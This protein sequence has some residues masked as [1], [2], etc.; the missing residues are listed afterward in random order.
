VHS[1]EG[2]RMAQGIVSLAQALR[3][4]T[5]AEGVEDEATAQVLRDI[6]V[7]ALQGYHF[8][9]PC[10]ASEFVLLSLFTDRLGIPNSP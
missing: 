5:V 3:L 2:L 9:R 8:A 1:V 7:N 10:P 4:R 6:G